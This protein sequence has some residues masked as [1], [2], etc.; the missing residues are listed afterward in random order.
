[1]GFAVVA[2]L[3][4]LSI[5]PSL[6][7]KAIIKSSPMAPATL[8]WGTPTFSVDNSSSGSPAQITCSASSGN[9]AFAVF[10]LK[11]TSISNEFA[12]QFL[13]VYLDNG[14]FASNGTSTTLPSVA[15]VRALTT[16]GEAVQAGALVAPNFVVR[17]VTVDS[18][19][20]DGY[21]RFVL[22]P[23]KSSTVNIVVTIPGNCNCAGTNYYFGVYLYS[24]VKGGGACALCAPSEIAQAAYQRL[25]FSVV[26]TA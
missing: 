17:S 20:N 12:N 3:V 26:I 7:G 25:R 6:A 10:T 16:G 18:P 4:A 24:Y 22:T 11:V 8:N 9:C 23:M 19:M 13:G 5:L 21:P 1:M 2:F 14:L 15:V